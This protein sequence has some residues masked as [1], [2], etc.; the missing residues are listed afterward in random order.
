MKKL[1]IAALTFC[2]FSAQANIIYDKSGVDEKDFIYDEYQ[3]Q[4]LSQQVQK[5]HESRSALGSAAKGAAVG[6]IGS[7]IG[8]GSGSEGAK[9]GAG[10]GVALGLL[11][12]AKD[13]KENEANYQAEKELVV[14]NCM[15]DRGYRVLN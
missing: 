9:K 14:K 1:L 6:A 7:A 8:G 3:C 4:E 5:S 15:S 12:G 13:R 11:G 10:I 2:V